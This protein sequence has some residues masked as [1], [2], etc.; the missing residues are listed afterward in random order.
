MSEEKREEA[1]EALEEAS[2][3][4]GKEEPV[5]V[6]A[7]EG[8]DVAEI[9]KAVGEFLKSLEEPLMKLLQLFLDTMNGEKLGKDVAVFYAQLRDSGMPEDVAVQ[10]T[11]EYFEK[12]TAIADLSKLVAQFV[13]KE[14]IEDED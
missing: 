2:E 6:K 3:A 1:R 11:K 5:V 7:G 12:R 8:G 4:L 13:K 10:M 9:L 14:I